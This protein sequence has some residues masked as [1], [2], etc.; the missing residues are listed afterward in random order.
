MAKYPAI[1]EPVGNLDSVRDT[2]L[3]LKQAFE[4]MSGQRGN[5]DNAM[6]SAA[7]AASEYL[8]QADAAATYVPEA[9]EDD[10]L[11]ARRNGEWSQV[12]DNSVAVGEWT[13]QNTT[14]PPPSSGQIRFNNATL[15]SV[16]T[17]YISNDTALGKDVEKIL[18]LQI[19]AGAKVLIQDKDEADKYVIYTVVALT[20]QTASDTTFTVTYDSMGT[21]LSDGQRVLFA[22][23]NTGSGTSPFPSDTTP[24]ED[25]T[26]AAGSALTYSRSDHVHPTDTDVTTLM[27]QMAMPGTPTGRLTSVSGTPVLAGTPS[28]SSNMYYTPYNGAV[29]WLYNGTIWQPKMF[30]ELTNVASDTTKNPSAVTA[31]NNYDFFVWDDSGTLR[32]S[33]GPVWTNLTTRSSGTALVRVNGIWMNNAAITNGPAAQ[34]GVYV[35]SARSNGAAQWVFQYATPIDVGAFLWIWNTFNR[36]RVSTQMSVSTTWAYGPAPLGW[37]I[38]IGTSAYLNYFMTGLAEDS[39]DSFYF[40]RIYSNPGNEAM[41]I[42]L[43]FDSATSPSAAGYAW[44]ST[45]GEQV[46]AQTQF[47][48]PPQLGVHYIAALELSESGTPEVISYNAYTGLG[49]TLMM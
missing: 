49:L 6:L 31:S 8:T 39:V 2:A 4:I 14:T 21:T 33:R 19:R 24:L 44:M 3:A 16:T 17:V 32:L 12:P 1:P 43:G 11:Y 30:S 25:G 47:N 28:A 35:G 10:E 37:R 40:A 48:F 26:G 20:A 46:T 36:V 38:A 15:S 27:T 41:A 34:R 23:A 7:T 9:P 18:L 22:V 5:A 45:A 29:I 13:Y 42:G